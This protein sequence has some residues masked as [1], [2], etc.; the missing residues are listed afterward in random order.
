MNLP[1]WRHTNGHCRVCNAAI[2][3]FM[4]FG[5]MPIANGFLKVEETGNEYFFELAP[6]FCNACGM[7]QLME[8]PRPEKMFHE[9]YAFYSSTSR[10]MQAHFQAFAHDQWCAGRSRR[11][12]RRRARQQ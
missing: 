6:A 2:A 1:G 12:V 4:S 9:Q 7:F 3:P 10:Y 11:S 5:R 8:Q